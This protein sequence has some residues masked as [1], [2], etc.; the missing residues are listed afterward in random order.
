MSRTNFPTDVLLALM[1]TCLSILCWG[2]IPN[3]PNLAEQLLLGSAGCL[4]LIFSLVFTIK[5]I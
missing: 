5:L 4:F 3:M 2:S 1:F